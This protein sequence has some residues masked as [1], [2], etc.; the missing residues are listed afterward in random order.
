MNARVSVR[1]WASEL[2]KAAVWFVGLGLILWVM[3]LL[4]A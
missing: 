3:A 2:G 4:E 1:V